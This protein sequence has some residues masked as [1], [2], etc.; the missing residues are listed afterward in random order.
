MEP[1]IATAWA[2]L[3]RAVEQENGLPETV[4][5]ALRAFDV[6]LS[7]VLALPPS[8]NFADLEEVRHCKRQWRMILP[9]FAPSS[10]RSALLLEAIGQFNNAWRWMLH[11]KARA[12]RDD[13]L[14]SWRKVVFDATQ[15]CI[16][17]L[18]Q[19]PH[20]VVSRTQAK[21]LHLVKWIVWDWRPEVW[22]SEAFAADISRAWDA[23]RSAMY[24]QQ[25]DLAKAKT[26]AIAEQHA[27]R[28]QHLLKAKGKPHKL[29]AI[30]TSMIIQLTETVHPA[31]SALQRRP[32]EVSDLL[33]RWTAG[34]PVRGRRPTHATSGLV[35]K[36][37]EMCGDPLKKDVT[38][39]T[40]AIRKAGK[41]VEEPGA[42][43]DPDALS[44]E[45][46]ADGS[47]T[48]VKL[49]Y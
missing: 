3:R 7:A 35:K 13:A 17:E 48:F 26:S 30:A 29:Q 45:I 8:P 27:R 49:Y 23:S 42:G 2:A 33:S 41:R 36:L 32:A 22:Q 18:S 14:A 31:F 20:G 28:Y 39:S 24:K 4:P 44:E 21:A 25:G 37:S 19:L 16:T 1:E 34:K 40:C 43:P 38:I 11:P 12:T 9:L 47:R 46:M 5:D 15:A 10:D 6:S